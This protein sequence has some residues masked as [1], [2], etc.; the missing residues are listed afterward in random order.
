MHFSCSYYGVDIG[1][2]NVLDIGWKVSELLNLLDLMISTSW[3]G[4]PTTLTSRASSIVLP[5]SHSRSSVIIL[6]SVLAN[7][8]QCPHARGLFHGYIP[9]LNKLGSKVSMLLLDLGDNGFCKSQTGRGFRLVPCLS[10]LSLN[11]W[12]SQASYFREC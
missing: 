4:S 9:A 1:Q 8:A 11:R 3:A 7:P 12:T 2:F 5:R 10:A 6:G